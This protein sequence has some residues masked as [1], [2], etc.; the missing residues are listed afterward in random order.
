MYERFGWNAA[1]MF[2]LT[3][4]VTDT[5]SHVITSMD[6]VL[7]YSNQCLFDMDDELD[8]FGR[9]YTDKIFIRLCM[10]VWVARHR[11]MAFKSLSCKKVEGAYIVR[12]Q[13]DNNVIEMELLEMVRYFEQLDV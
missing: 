1:N 6:A 2:F 3:R 7:R 4:D 10:L 5:N 13:Y 9:N 8:A 11:F 12:L